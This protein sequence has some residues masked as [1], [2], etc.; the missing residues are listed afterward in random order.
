MLVIRGLFFLMIA[1]CFSAP[2]RKAEDIAGTWLTA[3]KEGHIKIYSSY[4]KFYGLITWLKNPIDPE[5]GKTQLDINNNDPKLRNRPVMHLL[6][7]TD[8]VFDK[9]LN[10]WKDGK[11]YDPKSGTT[12]ELL[13]NMP[14]DDILQMHFYLRI[15]ELGKT[16]L[17]TRVTN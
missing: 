5:T 12:A 9:A 17:W 6:V 11:I 3:D 13:C 16:S 10:K 2:V 4:G 14:Q 7:L 8:L 15:Q 1:I